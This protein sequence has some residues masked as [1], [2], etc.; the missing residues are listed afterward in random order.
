MGIS[1][2]LVSKNLC[3]EGTIQ[4][5]GL[6]IGLAM[7]IFVINMIDYII[8]PNSNMLASRSVES[9]SKEHGGGI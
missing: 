4:N 2:S 3:A 1:S 6:R 5:S 9:G 7:R 8:C